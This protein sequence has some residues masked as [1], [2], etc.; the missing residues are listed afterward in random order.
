MAETIGLEDLEAIAGDETAELRRHNHERRLTA[1]L[2]PVLAGLNDVERTVLEF[3]AFLP[4]DT[5]ALPW[6]KTL[7]ET[8]VPDA[9][10][11]SGLI[12]D[13][14]REVCWRLTRLT[15]FSRAGED[16]WRVRV[17]R[18]VQDVV[19]RGMG[20]ARVAEFQ[21]TVDGFVRGRAEELRQTTRWESV[22]WEL[23]PL[24]ALANL[25]AETRQRWSA[26]LLNQAALR[27]HTTAE[28][29]RAEPPMRRALAVH[30]ASYG[31]DHP[32]VAIDLSNLAQL[33]MAT[34]RLSEAE[35]LM[36][37]ALAMGEASYGEDHPDIA[38]RLNNL[39]AL[40]QATNR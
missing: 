11:P 31:K 32:D 13:P 9:F 34:N 22:R 1:V 14:W 8:R 38:I 29:A 7:V 15:L 25:W 4:A 39:A 6:L 10:R 36:R 16:A 27:W 35:P 30:E 26:W 12:A 17:H 5:V 2:E 33:L 20:A 18:L 23:E 19:K 24:D 28:W 37:R 21:G 40:L 3:A